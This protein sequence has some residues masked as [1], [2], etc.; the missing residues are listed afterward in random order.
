MTTAKP[1]HS[2]IVSFDSPPYQLLLN[3]VF[4]IEMLARPPPRT[5][6]ANRC[7]S[8]G[9]SRTVSKNPRSWGLTFPLRCRIVVT[10][11]PFDVRHKLR[12]GGFASEASGGRR[13][14]TGRNLPHKRKTAELKRYRY[15]PPTTVTLRVA[16]ICC[17]LRFAQ[18]PLSTIVSRWLSS[19]CHAIPW[20]SGWA[21][22]CG[23]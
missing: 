14:G 16:R 9:Q 18:P 11:Q 5:H 7:R 12:T 8:P 1:R 2:V 19:A 10:F 13:F 22:P 15:L 23:Q 21:W 20:N 4:K 3:D 6:H 17:S